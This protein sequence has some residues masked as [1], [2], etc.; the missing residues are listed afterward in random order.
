MHGELRLLRAYHLDR[1]I[2]TNFVNSGS[3][4][5]AIYRWSGNI[6]ANNANSGASLGACTSGDVISMAVDLTP[7][8]AWMRKNGGN[9]NGAPIASQ[10]PNTGR[11]R[12]DAERDRDLCS[13]GRLRRRE[14]G[15]RTT[16]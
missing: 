10:N 15:D 4:C 8:K 16:P 11:G 7:R 2:H 3:K 1:H 9:W 12:R 14:H 5:V 13:G 6:Y